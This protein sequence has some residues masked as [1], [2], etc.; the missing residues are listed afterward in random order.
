MRMAA[1]EWL[2]R[3]TKLNV[4]KAKYG[5]A[6]HKALFLLALMDMLEAGESVSDRPEL[7]S[8]LAF[9]F[10][11]LWPIVAYR[12]TQQPDIRM[13]FH[14]LSSDRLRTPYM[15]DGD[16]SPA[17]KTTRYVELDA[18]FSEALDDEQ[19]RR[20]ARRIL[21][22]RWFPPAERNGL[23]ALYKIPVPTDDQIARDANFQVPN[24]AKQVGR[25]ARFR[26]DVVSAYNYTCALT[27][28][29]VTTIDGCS[30]V[31][32]AHICAFKDSRNNDSRN[33]IALCK[34]THWLF[35][36]GLWSI[37][38]NYRIIVAKGH[39]SESCPDQN[40]L[41][42]YEGQRLRLP[43]S[44]ALWPDRKHLAWHRKERLKGSSR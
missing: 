19:F 26:L 5:E 33:G 42:E 27:G 30:I 36:H 15:A 1:E 24:D 35:D 3:L 43:A 40:P 29:R 32:A 21:I 17:K 8:E 31:H 22:A 23:Y 20:R 28:Y 18:E 4:Y 7:T 6:P 11:A 41:T 39:L 34:N 38:E 13:P 9:R 12:R 14:H 16:M 25:Q 37:D 2:E 44:R 10:M